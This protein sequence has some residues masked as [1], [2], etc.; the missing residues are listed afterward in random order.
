MQEIGTP[1]PSNTTE[2][3]V[4]TLKSRIFSGELRPGTRL[5]ETELSKAFDVGR[6]RIRE[7]FR[8]LVGE[9]HLESL[10]NR[11]VAVRRYTRAELLDMGRV[12]EVLESLAARLAAEKPLTDE[13]RTALRE[14]QER[15]DAAEAAQDLETYSREN[16]AYHTLIE[17]IADNAHLADL[18][19][20]VRIPYLGLRL[21]RIFEI[22][23][24]RQSNEGHRFVTYAI[25]AGAQDVAEAAMRSHIRAGNT[26]TAAL[27]DDVFD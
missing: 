21:P 9:G 12:R 20:R 10:A 22:E 24:M 4:A 16:R 3:I 17:T 19:E 7:A 25:L 23:Q 5:I 6:G 2:D 13:R 15:M 18:I 27:P 8:V 14:A 11:G 26:H 1:H